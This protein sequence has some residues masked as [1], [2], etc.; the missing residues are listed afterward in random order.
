MQRKWANSQKQWH[1]RPGRSSHTVPLTHDTFS[2][3][4]THTHSLTRYY[5]C[6]FG[7]NGK[8][9][10]RCVMENICTYNQWKEKKE[11]NKKPPKQN[12][13]FHQNYL[14]SS[15]SHAFTLNLLRIPYRF[16]MCQRTSV[17]VWYVCCVHIQCT[18]HIN[19]LCIMFW[20][21]FVLHENI[22][23]YFFCGTPEQRCTY[24]VIHIERTSTV[25]DNIFL[26]I[27]VLKVTWSATE[28]QDIPLER[29]TV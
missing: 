28:C 18:A 3:E 2:P 26:L 11:N 9:R 1:G 14:K 21:H 20:S 4:H 13:N 23:S 10:A 17:S 16:R 25:P 29:F 19:V 8:R 6:A 22:V 7:S 12:I 24:S 27:S 5:V 15:F